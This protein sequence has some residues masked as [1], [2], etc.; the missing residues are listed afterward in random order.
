[1]KSRQ[2]SGSMEDYLE[3]ILVLQNENS[4]AKVA[5]AKEI[6]E[7]LD[8]K[9]SSVTNALKQLSEKG[10]I[11]YDRYSYITLTEKGE[12][13]AEEIH[14]RHTTLTE[15]LEKTLGIDPDK[16]EDN[17]CRMEHIMDKEVITRIA[18]FNDY[19]KRK[20]EVVDLG[21]FIEECEKK[22]S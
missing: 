5:R 13:Y 17:A 9:M 10:Y 14:F 16:A 18:A 12:S 19:M 3:A 1:M 21:I 20:G 22:G 15:F 7:K 8:V 2:L 11:N 4:Q 6:S